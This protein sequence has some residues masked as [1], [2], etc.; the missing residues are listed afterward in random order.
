MRCL[1]LLVLLATGPAMAANDCR[2]LEAKLIGSWERRGGDGFFEEM[3]FSVEDGRHGFD[4]WLHQRPEL[5][6]ASWRLEGCR[7]TIDPGDGGFPPFH[8]DIRFRGVLMQLRDPENA[9]TST[10]SRIDEKP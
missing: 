7:L 8:Y 1:L 10:Y 5:V 4:S 3:A 2:S 6:D 9:T